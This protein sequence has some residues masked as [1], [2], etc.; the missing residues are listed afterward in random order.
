MWQRSIQRLELH[1]SFVDLS[2][3]QV[4]SS[5][6]IDSRAILLPTGHV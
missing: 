2:E 1:N 4:Q 3:K 6:E 5:L